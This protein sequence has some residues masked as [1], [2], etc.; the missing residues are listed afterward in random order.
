MDSYRSEPT[1]WAILCILGHGQHSFIEEA[2]SAW[3]ST[4][5]RTDL[6]WSQ[7]CSFLFKNV[8]SSFIGDSQK[9]ET[10]QYPSPRAWINKVWHI[11]AVEYCCCSIP[12]VL[13]TLCDLWTEACQASL[14]ME[15]SRQEYW[16]G[17]PSP[18]PGDLPDPC[19]FPCLLR[20]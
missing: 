18:T 2:E 12:K 15:F 20:S 9:L 13:P 5:N 7:M 6:R 3:L 1:E 14:S 16:S 11:H 4:G 19:L 10:T 17:S 8:Q